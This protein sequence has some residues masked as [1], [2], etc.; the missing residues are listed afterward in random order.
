MILISHRGNLD[1]P[2]P[3]E[4]NRIEYIEN[5]LGEGYQVEVDVWW[6][7]GFYLGHDEPEYLM[8]TL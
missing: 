5:A 7:D 4:E 3:K 6:W 8:D 1:G 2:T